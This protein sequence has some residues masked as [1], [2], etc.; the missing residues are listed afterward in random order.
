VIRG[1]SR[2]PGQDTRRSS[3]RTPHQLLC[4]WRAGS[5]SSTVQH[6]GISAK[7]PVAVASPASLF[8]D[9][10]GSPMPNRCWPLAASQ[11]QGGMD[12]ALHGTNTKKLTVRE[13]SLVRVQ[14]RN[15]S[16]TSGRWYTNRTQCHLTPSARPILAILACVELR[17]ADEEDHQPG[18]GFAGAGA[19][20]AG[21]WGADRRRVGHENLYQHGQR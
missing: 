1:N 12:C 3:S 14:K 4:Y 6:S 10:V 8:V 19:T 11:A 18:V 2:A 17:T 5:S 15:K 7:L 20:Q 16:S 9:D 21:R 13:R